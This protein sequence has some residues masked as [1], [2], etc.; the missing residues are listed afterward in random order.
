MKLVIRGV[1]PPERRIAAELLLMVAGALVLLG[2]IKGIDGLVVAA[3]GVLVGATLLVVVEAPVGSVPLGYALAISVAALANAGTYFSVLALALLVTLPALVIRHGLEDAVRR[4]VRW[5]V[6]GCG[7]GLTVVGMRALVPGS[8]AELLLVHASVAGAVFLVVELVG[9]S[10]LPT[11]TAPPMHV[12]EAWPVHISLLCA[13][14]LIT[15]A[16]EKDPWMATVALV[17]LLMTKFAFDR[18]AAAREA[19]QQTIKA[20]SIVPEVAGVTPMGHGERSAVYAVALARQL[21]L[22]SD[23]IERVATAA[24]LHHIGYVTLDNPEEAR[25]YEDRMRLAKQG[26][27]ILRET[28]FLSDV[29][30]LVE[31]V[32]ALEI[33]SREAAVVRIATSFDQLVLEDPAR[34]LGALQLIN[35]NHSDDPYG[36][37]AA[38]V[39]RQVLEE[40]PAV[41][42]RAIA[43]GA[44]LIEA[45]AA[46]GAHHG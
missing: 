7:C 45:A 21:G 31:S 29:G 38:L 40:D 41:V 28:E 17:P 11:A 46:S 36:A 6:A 23:A 10:V 44:P 32:H 27:D 3:V 8:S 18:Y 14:G 4:A 24:R 19:Y 37:A 26:G 13:A 30:E 1:D 35:F 9:R 16:F 33:T 25:T 39:L 12:R 43:S 34:A 42:D 20:L 22:T 15:V 2:D 5:L